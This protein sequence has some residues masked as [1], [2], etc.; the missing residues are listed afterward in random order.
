MTQR[1]SKLAE[2]LYN[3]NFEMAVEYNESSRDPRKPLEEPEDVQLLLAK[4]Y[5]LNKNYNTAIDLA[6]KLKNSRQMKIVYESHL[7]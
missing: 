6:S 1:L 4:A 7:L 3:N 2:Y 5:F